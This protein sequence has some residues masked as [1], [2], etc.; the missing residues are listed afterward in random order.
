MPAR[1]RAILA[2]LALAVGA[3]LLI[4]TVAEGVLRLHA[5]HVARA[6]EAAREAWLESHPEAR[7]LPELSGVLALGKR[8]QLG[9][10]KGA[11]VRTNDIG[12]RGPDY[13]PE[14]EPGTVRIIL[15]GDSFTFGEG[16]AEP[17]VYASLL[18][19]RLD[20]AR[21]G[22]RHEVINAGISGAHTH[23]VMNR[24]EQVIAAYGP[25]LYVYGFTVNDFEGPHYRLTEHDAHVREWLM[26]SGHSPLY[27]VRWGTWMLLSL[28]AGGDPSQDAYVL[29]LL[30]NS[31]PQSPA[32]R[33]FE[34][35]LDRFAAL[36][37]ESD[38]CA[39]VF[40]HTHLNDLDETHP[41]TPIYDRVTEAARRRGLGVTSSLP[42]FVG[43]DHAELWIAS[44]DSHP[45]ATGHALLAE[46]LAGGLL[47]LPDSCWDRARAAAERTRRTE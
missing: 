8:N 29:E 31:D 38:V 27:L 44:I 47:A 5:W 36:A 43:L 12:L 40:I 14:P 1:L 10:H 39:H 33:H 16:V 37:A 9:M 19:P 18:G 15:A 35:G 34:R 24:L 23:G 2:R 46:T 30:D 25:G 41:F 7:D 26:W 22:T 4:A 6:R 13:T 45:N 17:E 11:V 3:L 20:R 42:A 28:R 32:W 21:P